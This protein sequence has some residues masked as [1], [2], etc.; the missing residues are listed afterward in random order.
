MTPPGKEKR[1]GESAVRQ[2]GYTVDS[3][4]GHSV[5][6]AFL[7]R[8]TRKFVVHALSSERG[9][10]KDEGPRIRLVLFDPDVRGCSE[11][12]P[13][14]R[15]AIKV[16]YAAIDPADSGVETGTKDQAS[17]TL[18]MEER[19]LLSEDSCDSLWSRLEESNGRFPTSMA[20]MK[21]RE[22]MKLGIL[23]W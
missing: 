12:T 20:K 17:T 5:V 22:E 23:W 8:N 15:E 9:L 21:F 6:N 11:E 19:L 14:F 10:C 4:V 7:G 16:L 18:S 1:S 3:V 13:A 2:N